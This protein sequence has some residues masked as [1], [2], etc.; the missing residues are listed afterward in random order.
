MEAEATDSFDA[1]TLKYD[2]DLQRLMPDTWAGHA[3]LML[4]GVEILSAAE[5][6]AI[7]EIVESVAK[8]EGY[9]SEKVAKRVIRKQMY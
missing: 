8:K 7:I 2:S 9:P 4:A 1:Q 5:K 3:R 6:K